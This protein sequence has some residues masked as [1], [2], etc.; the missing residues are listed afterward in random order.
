MH[1]S[2]WTTPALAILLLGIGLLTLSPQ[3]EAGFGGTGVRCLLCGSRGIADLILNVALFAPVGVLLAFRRMRAVGATGVALL[4]SAGIEAAQWFIPGREVNVRDVLANAIGSGLGAAMV[5][6]GPGWIRRPRAAAIGATVSALG[7]VAVVASVAP[8][9]T[10]LP[11]PTRVF[12]G[13]NP[14]QD[15]LETWTGVVDGVEIGGVEVPEGAGVDGTPV[16]AALIDGAPILLRVRAGRPSRGLAGL[17]I[18][19]DAETREI[20]LLGAEREDL[21]VRFRR[22]SSILRLDTPTVRFRG[23]LGG[24]APG[25]TI[26]IR[27]DELPR[28]PCVVIDRERMCAPPTSAGGAWRFLAWRDDAPTALTR[29]LDGLALA[30]LLTIPGLFLPAIGRGP[31][32]V[33]IGALAVALATVAVRAGLTLFALP[34]L[35]GTLGGLM[36]GIVAARALRDLATGPTGPIA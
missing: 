27:V 16:T 1:V 5:L 33:V 13:W 23:A 10:P 30:L 22:V 6:Y 31:A 29:V 14:R 24:R 34:E 17:F 32:A 21:V 8:L 18:V 36:A 15:H 4:L 2:R 3:P 28:R 19:N 7:A 9:L 26:E 20:L 12:V 11:A 25:T 35:V